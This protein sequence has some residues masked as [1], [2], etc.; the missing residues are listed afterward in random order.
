MH[1]TELINQFVELRVQGLSVP[2]ISQKIG[3][4]A[5]T[6]YDW[7]ERE[8]QRIHKL[9]LLMLEQAEEHVLGTQY[10]Q[11]ETLAKHLK[12]VDTEIASE[13]DQGVVSELKFSELIRLSAAFRSQ[14]HRLKIQATN[15][16]WEPRRNG[17]TRKPAG[18]APPKTVSFRKFP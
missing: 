17:R 18:R 6:L 3:V 10:H 4:P 8:R 14:L 7:N 13:I 5:S 2:K 12:A 9:R 16:M 11:Y 1:E 15:P